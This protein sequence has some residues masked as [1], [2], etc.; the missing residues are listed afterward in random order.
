VDLCGAFRRR[1]NRHKSRRPDHTSG[2]LARSAAQREVA[3]HLEI[4]LPQWLAEPPARERLVPRSRWE[5]LDRGKLCCVDASV[6]ERLLSVI[7]SSDSVLMEDGDSLDPVASRRVADALARKGQALRELGRFEDAVAVWDEQI[8]RFGEEPLAAAPSIAFEAWLSKARDLNHAARHREAVE[9]V[10]GL[11]ELCDGRDQTAATQLMIAQA[12]G[13]R[14]RALRSMGRRDDAVACDEEMIA[15]FG[16]AEE[17]ELRRWVAWALQHEARVLIDDGR[18]DDA[19]GVSQ[20]LVDRLA[21]ESAE[22]LPV[23]GQYVNA[24]IML[25]LRVGGP[26]LCE[27]VWFV[28]GVLV[29]ASGEAIN[30]AA[31]MLTRHELLPAPLA[32]SQPLPSVGESIIP[33][34]LVQQR[35]RARQALYA[36]RALLRRIGDTDDR[37]LRRLAAMAEVSAAMALVGRG[38]L[39]AGFG[40]FDRLIEDGHP[41]TVQ[42][43]QRLA[44]RFQHGEG[45]IDQLGTVSLLSL[46]AGMLGDGDARITKIAYDDSIA[47]HHNIS[48][49]TRIT[50]W[51]AKQLRPT[52]KRKPASRTRD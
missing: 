44:E 10:A 26:G 3:L 32:G 42:A 51:A 52:T 21:D 46:R 37:D 9:A 36:S 49:H 28:V 14:A 48:P 17:T 1:R 50:R 4:P 13:V 15:R 25:L 7:E 40:A 45:M 2:T 11:I 29:N 31:A 5:E 47:S 30:A 35:V 8:V 23:V 20:R 34:S 12:L 27:I 24:H 22:S 38:H 18:V 6:R 19:I 43:F 33:R 39:R 16:A 41:D